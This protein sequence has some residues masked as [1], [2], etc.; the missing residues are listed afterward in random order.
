MPFALP[1]FSFESSFL[2]PPIFQYFTHSFIFTYFPHSWFIIFQLH[3]SIL[4]YCCF[5]VLSCFTVFLSSFFFFSCAMSL[6]AYLKY[7]FSKYGP[8]L[9]SIQDSFCHCI[10]MFNI[11]IFNLYIYTDLVQSLYLMV[12]FLCYLY[13][14]FLISSSAFQLVVQN[15]FVCFK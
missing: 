9:I 5:I 11:S 2:L 10:V 15:S 12:I 7:L 13:L 14:F 4:F 3:F 6:L 8:L 1:V